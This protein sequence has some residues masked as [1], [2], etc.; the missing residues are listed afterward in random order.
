VPAAL[1]TPRAA[2]AACAFAVAVAAALSIP[3]PASAQAS[4][5]AAPFLAYES[6]WNARD[7]DGIL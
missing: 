7:L 1:R 3:L 5:P 6:A 2:E 4:D